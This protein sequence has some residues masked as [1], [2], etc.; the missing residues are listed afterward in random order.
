M[1]LPD[2]TQFA[3]LNELRKKMGAEKIREFTPPERLTKEETEK[4]AKGVMEIKLDE[5]R[6]LD[7]G[8]LAYKDSRVILHIR[9]VS[10]YRRGD[11]D[12]IEDLPRFHV[13][14]CD[15]LEYMFSIN[16]DKR[17]VGATREDGSFEIKIITKG[18][19]KSRNEKLI[20]CQNY[21]KKLGWEGC[22]KR[23]SQ[24]KMDS[25]VSGFTLQDFFKKYNK[26]LITETP[27]HTSD[28]APINDYSRDWDEVSKRK[29]VECGYRCEQC[30]LDLSSHQ[31]FLQCHHKNG[32]KN[33]NSLSNLIVLCLGCHVKEP[34][35]GHMRALPDYQ[36]FIQ[37]F[38]A[39]Q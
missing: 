11:S 14:Y 10:N 26:T 31:K 12:Q 24:K 32:Q 21:L 35:H 9:D 3:P 5:I 36:E 39:S 29:K 28:T 27:T 4:L 30:G 19:E 13:S 2:F 15:T 22:L 7:D 17:Y 16:R 23:S 37:I 34:M 38:G 8:T 6:V 25:L 20:I 33:D 1:K 18:K